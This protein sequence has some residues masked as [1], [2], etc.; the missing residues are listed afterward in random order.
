[1]QLFSKTGFLDIVVY[2]YANNEMIPYILAEVKQ[3]GYGIKN[4]QGGR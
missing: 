4:S 3:P 2:I 1:M